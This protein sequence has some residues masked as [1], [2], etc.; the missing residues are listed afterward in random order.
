M[1]ELEK[2]LTKGGI[3]A[4]LHKNNK[5]IAKSMTEGNYQISVR[6]DLIKTREQSSK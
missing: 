2:Y 5:T 6:D 3:D 4:V 1:K